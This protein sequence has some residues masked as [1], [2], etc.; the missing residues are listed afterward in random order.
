MRKSSRA[1]ALHRNNVSLT[2]LG[3]KGGGGIS[4]RVAFYYVETRKSAINLLL[5]FTNI[6]LMSGRFL[7]FLFR[8]SDV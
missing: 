1:S 3:Y 6:E 2:A 4:L 5:L 8:L 7:L